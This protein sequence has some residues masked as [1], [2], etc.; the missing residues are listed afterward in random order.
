M[1]ENVERV[2]NFTSSQ[3]Y[4]LM[5][6]GNQEFGF[7]KPAITYIQEKKI[8][9]R[10]KRSISVEKHSRSMSWGKFL[11]GR[12]FNLIGLEYDIQSKSTDEHPTIKGW[13]GSKDLIIDGQVVGDIKCFEPKN[14]ALYTDMILAKDVNRF[15]KEF[16]AEYWQLISNALI[17][18]VKKVEAISYMPFASELVTIREMADEYEDENGNDW[19]VRWIAD[20]PNAEL[21]YLPDGGYYNNLNKFRFDV[22]LEDEALLTD[23]VMKAIQILER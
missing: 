16:P 11:E 3:I 15:K 18:Q 5:S 8:E 10:L 1:V 13:T 9:R 20:A 12:V 21:P 17:N 14:F 22:S 4:K 23:R 2:G 6:S 19:K 7:G